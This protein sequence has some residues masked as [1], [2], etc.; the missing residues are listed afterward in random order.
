[1]ISG[2]ERGEQFLDRLLG[3]GA[4][5]QA[6]R[7]LGEQIVTGS[8]QTVS[9]SGSGGAPTARIADEQFVRRA[10]EGVARYVKDELS[11]VEKQPGTTPSYIART[12][13]FMPKEAITEAATAAF[14]TE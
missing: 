1:M 2:S 3:A 11:C 14:V 12:L 13:A 5:E 8:V 10:A 4:R 9:S 7:W 6:V